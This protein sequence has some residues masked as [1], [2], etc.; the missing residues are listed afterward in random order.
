MRGDKKA[1]SGVIVAVLMILIVI[2][3]VVILWVVISNFIE[4]N[5][6]EVEAGLSTLDVEI[7]EGSLQYNAD[8]QKL[9]VLVERKIGAGNLSKVKFILEGDDGQTDTQV[10]GFEGEMG[11]GSRKMFSINDI[12]GKIVAI[13]AYP[14]AT[15]GGKDRD[16]VL[17]DRVV[18][19]G[20]VVSDVGLV[21]HWKLDGVNGDDTT[22][23]G[24]SEIITDSGRGKVLNL[25]SPGDYVNT[26]ITATDLGIESA[27]GEFTISTWV[28][29]EDNDFYGLIDNNLGD[30][31]IRVNQVFVRD[32]PDQTLCTILFNDNVWHHVVMIYKDKTVYGYVDFDTAVCSSTPNS[33][34]VNFDQ[35]GNPFYIG[36]RPGETTVGHS[37]I[38][39]VDDIKIYD[40]ALTPEE[41]KML[42][43]YS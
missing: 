15:V 29:T 26:G 22:F 42:Y 32:N 4:T 20:G 38:G 9:E 27:S 13:T 41:I 7:V 11:V 36:Y 1:V 33:L 23:Y 16:G 14:V 39:Q 21:A 2:A 3:A 19:S 18:V 5:L 10:V 12:E 8:D 37:L 17:K 6:E 31:S 28:K 35:S 43:K 40:R 30:I 24:T 34:M 25:V